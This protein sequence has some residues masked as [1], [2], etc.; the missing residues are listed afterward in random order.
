MFMLKSERLRGVGDDVHDRF[1]GAYRKRHNTH[2]RY[3]L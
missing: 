1:P 3:V 2:Y